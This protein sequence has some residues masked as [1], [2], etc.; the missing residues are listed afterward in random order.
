MQEILTAGSTQSNNLK[1]VDK[2]RLYCKSAYNKWK[3]PG[4]FD[5]KLLKKH[6]NYE[7]FEFRVVRIINKVFS[8]VQ[9]HF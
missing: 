4:F 9:K 5:L 6:F 8:R 3:I 1:G 2:K 7:N